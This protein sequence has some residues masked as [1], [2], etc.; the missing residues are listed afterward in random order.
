MTLISFVHFQ[1][2]IPAVRVRELVRQTCEAFEIR[3]LKGVVSLD[4]V[5]IAVVGRS[6]GSGVAVR[7]AAERAVAPV[8]AVQLLCLRGLRHLGRSALPHAPLCAWGTA[9]GCGWH[10]RIWL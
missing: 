6:L 1:G 2:G 8:H 9:S 7:L 3:I 4:H 5:Q 10:L